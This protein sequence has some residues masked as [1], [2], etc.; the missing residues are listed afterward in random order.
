MS[1]K[2][3]L[4]RA[5]Q[6]MLKRERRPRREY[7][8][9]TVVPYGPNDRLATKLVVAIVEGEGLPPETLERWWSPEGDIR[10][11]PEVLVD[12]V[13]WMKA[14]GVQR[15]V[16]LDRILGC[17]HEE[18]IDYPDGETCPLCPFWADRDRF[19]GEVITDA[20]PS[21]AP[22]LEFDDDPLTYSEY[23]QVH[24]HED[25]A[26][27]VQIYREEPDR[28]ILE[29][30][31]KAGTSFVWDEPFDTDEAAWQEFERALREEGIEDSAGP[32]PFGPH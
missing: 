5:R 14:Y 31:D 23:C 18:G 25:E 15:L 7:P 24:E 20:E 17:P 1:L 8:L 2:L 6:W 13:D 29:V 11:D 22:S 27:D 12:A 19:T 26:Y 30:V 21:P 16:H 9:A 10:N 3:K 4:D 28:W 32:P